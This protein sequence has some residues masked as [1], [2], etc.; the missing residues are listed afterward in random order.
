MTAYFPQKTDLCGVSYRKL[1]KQQQAR[2]VWGTGNYLNQINLYTSAIFT[3]RVAEH[4]FVLLSVWT[5]QQVGKFLGLHPFFASKNG[6][7]IKQKSLFLFFLYVHFFSFVLRGQKKRNEPKKRKPALS[8]E[9]L[10]FRN[11]NFR[12]LTKCQ[13][14]YG[15]FSFLHLKISNR[16]PSGLRPEPLTAYKVSRVYQES[17]S[18]GCNL[19]HRITI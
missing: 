4:R 16:I 13:Y 5:Q 10:K 17:P 12:P 11:E 9:I 18:A 19:L 8:K 1:H 2:F 6:W 3:C 15:K 7:N 14:R